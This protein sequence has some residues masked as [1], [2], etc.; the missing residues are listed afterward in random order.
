MSS[1]QAADKAPAGSGVTPASTPTRKRAPPAPA[2]PGSSKKMKT[3][4]ITEDPAVLFLFICLRHHNGSSIDYVGVAKDLGITK[5]AAYKRW[6]KT[7]AQCE[8]AEAGQAKGT[9]S[10]PADEGGLKEEMSEE[11]V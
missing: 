2:T 9:R 6:N 11:D 10:K 5:N 8:A 3:A 4:K 1:K 7:K